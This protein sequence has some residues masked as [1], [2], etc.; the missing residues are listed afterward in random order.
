MTATFPVIQ[1][2]PIHTRPQLLR[3]SRCLTLVHD[4]LTTS[5]APSNFLALLPTQPPVNMNRLKSKN[6][7]AN[8]PNLLKAAPAYSFDHYCAVYDAKTDKKRESTGGNQPKGKDVP[9]APDQRNL[10]H[11]LMAVKAFAFVE[12]R[13]TFVSA[14][15]YR[16]RKRLMLVYPC[17]STRDRPGQR[18]TFRLTCS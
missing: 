7:L 3:P 6:R 11:D 10:A 1:C 2:R 16:A 5:L 12:V 14:Q 4:W 9:P 15:G 17:C 18:V 8:G 13:S